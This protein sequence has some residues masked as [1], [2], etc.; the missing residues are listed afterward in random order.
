MVY[1]LRHSFTLVPPDLLRTFKYIVNQSMCC[2]SLT[3]SFR[4]GA[5]NTSN[6]ELAWGH[7]RTFLGKPA[8]HARTLAPC[9]IRGS[10]AV[11]T[12]PRRIRGVGK[13]SAG[14]EAPTNEWK[15]KKECVWASANL[16]RTSF[17]EC[18]QELYYDCTLRSWQ[19][20]GSRR[21]T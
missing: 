16:L 11:R 3:I 8:E 6:H 18:S 2:R 17:P 20:T 4:D 10:P 15:P 21:Q 5:S 19:L 1:R 13:S 9:I 14:K 12:V 7:T